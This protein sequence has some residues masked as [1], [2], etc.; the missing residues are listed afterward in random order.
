MVEWR[1]AFGV[2]HRDRCLGVV[3][4]LVL[5]CGF[6]MGCVGSDWCGFGCGVEISVGLWVCHGFGLAWVIGVW[7]IGVG[8]WIFAGGFFFFLGDR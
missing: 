7:V 1:S 6:A 8:L 2:W 5:G 4:R 3:W